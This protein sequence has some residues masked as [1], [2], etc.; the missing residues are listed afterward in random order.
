MCVPV[1]G[2]GI[3]GRVVYVELRQVMAMFPSAEAMLADEV[4]MDAL[5]VFAEKKKLCNMH[6]ERA[7]AAVTRNAR[8]KL[9]DIERITAG[10]CLREWIRLHVKYG[11]REPT[12]EKRDDL[13]GG[14]VPLRAG[15]LP[16]RQRV[17]PH[18]CF[19]NH[20]VAQARQSN[21]GSLKRPQYLRVARQAA[22]DWH[23]ATQDEVDAASA[24][25]RELTDAICPGVCSDKVRPSA[26]SRSPTALWGMPSD[27]LPVREEL[28]LHALA[29]EPGG[30]TSWSGA[31]RSC[32]QRS[33]F[34]A[35]K[36]QLPNM[37]TMIPASDYA[38]THLFVFVVVFVIA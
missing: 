23:T 4:F 6:L 21:G 20:R 1:W 11:G 5:R 33:A 30:F 25:A 27:T 34:V 35:D 37:Q 17:D 16:K 7:L 29:K 32:Y 14:G 18:F 24:R 36:G 38:P 28:L 8:G 31:E 3:G 12:S 19:I 26:L 22:K 2:G 15:G 10:A 13:V 9:M